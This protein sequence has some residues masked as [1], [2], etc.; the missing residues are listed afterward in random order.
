MTDADDG[1][2]T[3]S[4][5]VVDYENQVAVKPAFPS[6]VTVTLRLN[7]VPT[8]FEEYHAQ[9]LYGEELPLDSDSDLVGVKIPGAGAA[10]AIDLINKSLASVDAE[11]DAS[12]RA[13]I[14]SMSAVETALAEHDFG[15]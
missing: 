5:R 13:A 2:P 8:V 11:A 6:L 15:Q 14:A 3:E 1:L 4:L 12:H 7:R 9:V 10:R